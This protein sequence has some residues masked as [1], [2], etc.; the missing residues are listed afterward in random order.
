MNARGMVTIL[1]LC[2][3]GTMVLPGSLGAVE[4][5]APV[6][7]VDPF[8]GT[9][10]YKAEGV[11]GEGNTFPGP[12]R[13]HGMVQLSP[14][15]DRHFAGYMY[16]DEY[17]EGFSHTHVTGT[18]CWGFGNIL[19]MPRT[20]SVPFY[21]RGYRSGFSHDTVT[22]EQSGVR[23]EL[24]AT[25]RTGFH[26]YTFPASDEARILLDVSHH[27]DN[28]SNDPI[29][30]SIQIKDQQTL[31]GFVTVPYPFCNGQTPYTVHF[32]MKV[33]KPFDSYG[34]WSGG[35]PKSGN[36]ILNGTDIGAY[37]NYET[38]ANEEILVKIG[39]SYV[40]EDQALLN[41]TEEIPHWDFDRVRQEARTEWNEK[42]S[43]IQVEGGNT[44]DRR[45]VQD[46]LFDHLPGPAL[47]DEALFLSRLEDQ[48]DP[49]GEF[50]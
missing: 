11:M 4:G 42:L 6:D 34:L 7:Y 20:G 47:P 32:A 5:K 22:L 9:G 35:I 44:R 1:T 14:D 8:I 33:S 40:S 23:A 46:P 18:G 2:L 19:V 24:T 10:V 17:I 31:T 50:G 37:L 49:A 41:L 26:R 13:P 38:E 45:V 25:T 3:L 39:I 12:T 30:G 27:L 21:E 36:V 48:L 29:D 15:T 28:S 16:H 43:R